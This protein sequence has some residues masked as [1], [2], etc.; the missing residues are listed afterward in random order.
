MKCNKPVI[1]ILSEDRW[2]DGTKDELP[3]LFFFKSK[4]MSIYLFKTVSIINIIV[5]VFIKL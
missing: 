4:I 3:S 5:F 2:N 1:I